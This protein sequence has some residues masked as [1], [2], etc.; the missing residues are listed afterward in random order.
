MTLFAFWTTGCQFQDS[1]RVL[2]EVWFVTYPTIVEAVLLYYYLLNK[3]ARLLCVRVS[4]MLFD[5]TIMCLC[6]LHRFSAL[7]ASSGWLECDR[8]VDTLVTVAEFNDATLLDFFTSSLALRTNGNVESVFFVKVG[9]LVT[10]LLPFVWGVKERLK[11]EP[12]YGFVS[13]V[14]SVLAIRMRNAGGLGWPQTYT[15]IAKEKSS[16]VLS[17]Y[18]LLRFGYVMFDDTG[19]SSVDHDGLTTVS[20][21]SRK[22]DTN[23]GT[24]AS[25]LMSL[26]DWDV[27]TLLAPAR[28]VAHLW[29]HRV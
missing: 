27:L 18:E 19:R 29:N 10:G 4:D 3:L 15:R 1:Q 22:N 14:E 23:N 17:S 6:A 26:D 24:T 8:R 20:I 9:V 21:E 13:H 2:S 28:K 16:G 11:S 25:C 12:G 7:L 5:P